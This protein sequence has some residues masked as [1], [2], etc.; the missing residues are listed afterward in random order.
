MSPT[1][2][3]ASLA[4]GNAVTIPFAFEDAVKRTR[5]ALQKEGFGVLCEIDV[6]KT[7]KDKI[8]VDSRPYTILGACNPQL[9]H[10]ALTA[11]RDLGLLL[12]CNVV[13]S[14]EATGTRI[15]TI[16]AAAMM[17]MVGNAELE[18]IAA[19]VNER[20]ARVLQLVAE[21]HEVS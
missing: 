21:T 6:A 15:A 7:L 14:S 20:L 5:E 8:D 19:E 3:S 16:D 2:K 13:V 18:P 4:Y 1:T 10:R 11:E 9:A 17:R 12:P